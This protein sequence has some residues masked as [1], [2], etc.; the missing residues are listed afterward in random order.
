MIIRSRM[1]IKIAIL[2]MHDKDDDDDNDDDGDN[3][4]DSDDIIRMN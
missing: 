2:L 4:D 1:I 3:S